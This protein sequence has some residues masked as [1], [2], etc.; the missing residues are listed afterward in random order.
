[1]IADSIAAP[2]RRSRLPG[3]LAP[4]PTLRLRRLAAAGG[5]LAATVAVLIVALGGGS[6]GSSLGLQQAA[7]LTLGPAK[8]PAP[9]ER[10]GSA[11]ELVAA[12]QGIHFPYWEEHFGWRSTGQRSDRVRGREVTTVFYANRRGQRIGYAIV[13]GTPAPG[14]G[15]GVLSWRHG[16]SYRLHST[17]GANVVTWLRGGHLCVLSGRDIGGAALV[18]LASWGEPPSAA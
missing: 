1:M 7:A 2:A 16:S 18:R 5:L 6:G 13:A 8:A 15:G 14:I 12:V 10:R 9:A 3:A 11:T 4:A 17:Q